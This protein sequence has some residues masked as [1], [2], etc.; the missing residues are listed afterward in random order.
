MFFS[1]NYWLGMVDRE[2]ADGSY[3]CIDDG[4]YSCID[5]GTYR[6]IDDGTYSC[7]DDGRYSCIDD[8]SYIICISAITTGSVWWTGSQLMVHT[9]V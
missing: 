7:I 4:T 2:P 5:D 6:C 8:L 3:G 1:D 9:A